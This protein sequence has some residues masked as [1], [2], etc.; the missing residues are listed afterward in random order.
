MTFNV[1]ISYRE[2]YQV[3]VETIFTDGTSYAS[4]YEHSTEAEALQHAWA[5]GRGHKE[6]ATVHRLYSLQAARAV[7]N[8]HAGV[9]VYRLA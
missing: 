2:G 5:V 7:A 8:T 6:V 9:N 4:K 1:P 3:I